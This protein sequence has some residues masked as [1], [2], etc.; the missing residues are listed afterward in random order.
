M[1]KPRLSDSKLVCQ[2][3]EMFA[4]F[5][6]TL[7]VRSRTSVTFRT[8]VF[9]VDE[10]L[11]AIGSVWVAP[12]EAVFAIVPVEVICTMR[13]TNCELPTVSV[14]SVHVIV[15]EPEQEPMLGFAETN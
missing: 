8:V 14:P 15:V 12:T 10:L 4:L 11:P 13:S 1:L 9:A 7:K 3:M 2:V 5:C 6:V